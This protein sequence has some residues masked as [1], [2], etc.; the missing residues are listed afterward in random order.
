MDGNNAIG[1]FVVPGA[2][3]SDR[4]AGHDF[5]TVPRVNLWFVDRDRS[6][7]AGNA[8]WPWRFARFMGRKEGWRCVYARAGARRV[9]GGGRAGRGI[10]V[11]ISGPAFGFGRWAGGAGGEDCC[12]SSRKNQVIIG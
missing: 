8:P 1:R 12:Q 2:L 3:D 6:R 7:T 5:M 9:G 11:I 10:R 4:I